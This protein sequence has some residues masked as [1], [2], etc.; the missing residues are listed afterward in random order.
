MALPDAWVDRIFTKLT[1]TYGRDFLSRWEGL[2]MRAVKADWAHELSGYQA[3]PSAIAHALSLLPDG[4]PP[5]VQDFKVLCRGAPRTDTLALP[6]PKL[7]PGRL[8]EN[9]EAIAAAM[10]KE[11]THR[12]DWARTLAARI[13]RKVIVPT[14]FQKQCLR[15]VFGGEELP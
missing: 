11:T 13:E 3:N 4:K 14:L 7:P 2:D 9:M 8:K 5:T 1:L 10:T 15:E 12:L 6:A